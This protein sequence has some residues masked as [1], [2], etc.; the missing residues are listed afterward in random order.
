LPDRVAVVLCGATFCH[1]QGDAL[2]L[3]QTI[4]PLLAAA[5]AFIPVL[6]RATD[7][8]QYIQLRQ[9]ELIDDTCHALKYFERGYLGGQTADALNATSQHAFYQSG[10]ISDDEYDKWLK[11][12]DAAAAAKAKD[13]ACDATTAALFNDAHFNADRKIYATLLVAYQFGKLPPQDT[14]YRKL[15]D[16][17]QQMA[18]G[19]D[20]FVKQLYG[21]N[22]DAFVKN[23]TALAQSNID[24]AVANYN[25]MSLSI[26]VDLAFSD[27][28]LEAYA[29]QAGLN[30]YPVETDSG[31]GAGLFTKDG[32]PLAYIIDGASRYKIDGKAKVYGVLAMTPEHE[33]RLMTFGVDAEALPDTA[34]VT[35]D[36]RTKPAPTD[37][38][39]WELFGTDGWHKLATAFPGKRTDTGCLGGPCYVFPPAA[40][41]ALKATTLGEYSEVF[42][43]TDDTMQP[44]DTS[45]DSYKN[46]SIGN[47][48]FNSFL[49][50][51]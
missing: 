38:K 24:D 21:T 19:F 44:Y 13:A 18:G 20:G 14:N 39:P 50:L 32:R 35:L 11:G 33:L 12:A 8:D 6:A 45:I 5:L 10:R 49:K 22:Y 43:A 51:E 27:L 4:A 28:A 3:K 34:R 2:Q 15:T 16:E 41:A 23:A 36:V 47:Y 40:F 37:K 29:E 25:L 9:L 42:I 26:D 1:F 31:Y 17:E 48:Y 46:N 30:V 7:E